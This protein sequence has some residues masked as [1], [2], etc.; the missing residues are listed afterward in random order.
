MVTDSEITVDLETVLGGMR[1]SPIGAGLDPAH[2]TAGEAL[3][4]QTPE[5]ELPWSAAP[6]L[7]AQA[8]TEPQAM[9]PLCLEADTPLV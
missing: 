8:S 9:V 3:Y 4:L 2:A 6:A 7:A 1:A 5:L